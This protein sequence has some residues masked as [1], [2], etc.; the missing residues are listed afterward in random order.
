MTTLLDIQQYVVEALNE[1]HKEFDEHEDMT[2]EKVRDFYSMGL[3][4]DGVPHNFGN[5]ND[6]YESAFSLGENQGAL[7]TLEILYNMLVNGLNNAN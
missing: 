7:D 4:V 3:D 1:L 5:A 6:I 2:G